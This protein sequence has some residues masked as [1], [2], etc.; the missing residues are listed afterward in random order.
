MSRQ[1]QLTS[2]SVHEFTLL[3]KKEKIFTLTQPVLYKIEDKSN[4]ISF[5]NY[6]ET[7]NPT[8]IDEE[9]HIERNSFKLFKDPITS[10]FGISFISGFK[11]EVEVTAYFFA[12]ELIDAKDDSLNICL[13]N[14]LSPEPIMLKVHPGAPQ[15][16]IIQPCLYISLHHCNELHFEDKRTFP[17]IIV[18]KSKDSCR[19]NYF[20]FEAESLLKLRETYWIGTECYEVLDIYL[21]QGQDCSICLTNPVTFLIIPCRHVCLCENCLNYILARDKKCPICR[22]HINIGYK[23][24]D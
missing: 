16:V 19:I 2:A 18:I 22:G 6:K 24:Y 7:H 3:S 9:I 21:S 1:S 8:Y 11:V 5:A 23:I 14:E 12:Y 17:I 15:Q 20:K 13:N 10:N 4:F